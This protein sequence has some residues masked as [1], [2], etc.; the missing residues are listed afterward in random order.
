MFMPKTKLERVAGID[1]N[2]DVMETEYDDERA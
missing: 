2:H 1:N